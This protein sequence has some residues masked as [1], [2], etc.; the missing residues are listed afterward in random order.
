MLQQDQDTEN[1]LA[2]LKALIFDTPEAEHIKIQLI[3]DEL[4]NGRYEINANHIAAKLLEYA[5]V[6]EDME[7]A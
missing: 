5:R 2:R 7:M 6:N 3:K 4:E 1:Q